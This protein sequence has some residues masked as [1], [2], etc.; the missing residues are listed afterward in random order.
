MRCLSLKVWGTL[1]K[2]FLM[3]RNKM[4]IIDQS[5]KYS[6]LVKCVARIFIMTCDV[7]F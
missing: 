4:S 1:K 2:N 7:G 3:R 5:V 6:N